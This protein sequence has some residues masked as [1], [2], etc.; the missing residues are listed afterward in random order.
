MLILF[1]RT[2]ILYLAAVVVIRIMGKRQ[3]GQLQPFELVI[4]IIIAE[5][6]V[7]PMQDKDVPLIEGL[8][9]VFTLLLLQYGVS[10]LL[11]KSEGARAIVC[12]VPSVLVHDGRIVEKELRRLRYNLSDLLEQLR[13]KDLPNIT[14]VEFAVLETN[15]DLSVIPKSQ[16]RPLQPEDLKIS[17]SYEGLPLSLIVDGKVKMGSLQKAQLNMEWL[18]NELQRHGVKRPTDV[19]YA[20]LSTDG[21][22]FVQARE[23]SAG[24]KEA[25]VS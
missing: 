1:G 17:T 21:A 8:V 20:S 6:V 14:D 22:L 5:L 10:L 13:V 4:T 23:S 25:G 15:G 18:Q 3:I 12:G 11:M 16:K 7:I 9:P 2:A 24:W 19:L